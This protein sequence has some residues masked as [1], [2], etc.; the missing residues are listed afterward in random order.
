MVPQRF[1]HPDRR[2]GRRLGEYQQGRKRAYYR[3]HGL[4]Q[5][6]CR[7]LWALDAL[8]RDKS[9]EPGQHELMTSAQGRKNG[10]A[11]E[12][13]KTQKQRAGRYAHPVCFAPESSRGGCGAQPARAACGDAHTAKESGRTP[14]DITVGIRSGDTP[15]RERRQLISNPPDILLTTPESLYLMLTS[16]ARS[17]LT[18]VDNCNCGRGAR[19][20][21]N[22]ARGASGGVP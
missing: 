9:T 2:A 19:P 22:Q 4:R 18:G 5:N 13:R 1:W 10:D 20:G 3:P 8:Y 6:P 11:R 21:G 12:T 16:A 7:F 17:T 14:P 15:A